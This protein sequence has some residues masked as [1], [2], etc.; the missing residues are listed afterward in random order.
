MSAPSRRVDARCATPV[1]PPV[2]WRQGYFSTVNPVENNHPGI[3]G[4]A[5]RMSRP[6]Y[7][8]AAG[9]KDRPTGL[10][11]ARTTVLQT[12][13][14]RPEPTSLAELADA[15]GLHVNTL[16]EHLEAL[17]ALNL[18][19]REQAPASG[20]GRPAWLYRAIDDSEPSEYAGLAAALAS[21]ITRTSSTP[22]EDALQAGRTWG[23]EL[24]QGRPDVPAATASAARRGVAEMLD[25]L[26]FEPQADTRADRVRLTRC[27]L[28]QAA[29]QFPEVVCAVHLGI[30][31]GALAEYGTDPER[32]SLTPFA[33]PGACSLRLL[34]DPTVR[35]RP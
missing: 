2:R 20:R 18:V 23:V 31:E 27:P 35:D 5:E 26:G 19:D 12:L 8:P 17:L 9:S 25:D 34:A 7:G 28:L 11:R 24:A 30:V 10:S 33:E 14:E 13:Q 4:T 3:A 16:R 21:V 32:A 22:S 6:G 29:R 1:D 15:T